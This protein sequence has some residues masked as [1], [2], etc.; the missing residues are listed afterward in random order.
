M[1]ILTVSCV[2][3]CRVRCCCAAGDVAHPASKCTFKIVFV[4]IVIMF[5]G[6]LIEF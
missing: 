4:I 1:K 2:N 3:Y 6:S 5:N